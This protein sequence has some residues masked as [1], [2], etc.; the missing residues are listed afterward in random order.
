MS[1]AVR[2]VW[3]AGRVVLG[4][5]GL[6][7]ARRR[8]REDQAG[9]G[10]RGR[11]FRKY[12]LLIVGL[13][14]LVLLLNSALDFW[15]AYDEN[16]AALYR[17]QQEKAASAARRIEEF[18]DEIERQ[19]GWT[20]A[21][22]WAA[23]PLEQRRF[24]Y[25][26]LL[27]QVPPITELIQLDDNG[28]EQL[29]VSRL[30]MDVVGSEKDYSEAPSFI[31]AR[32]HRVWF[33]PVYFRKESEPYMTLA[34]ARTG[35]NA[36]V[37][38][39]EVNLKLIWDV[40]TGLKIGRGGYAYVV[41]R[42]GRLIAH[43]DISLVLRNTDLAALPQVAAARAEAAGD[44][45]ESAGAMVAKG[46]NGDRVLTAHAAIA[47]LG[48]TVFVELPLS[49]AL[50]PLY[51]SALRTAALLA[52]ALVLATLAALFLARRMT[53]PIRELQAG[54]ARIGAGEL[55]RHIDIHTG[56]ELE[57][58][59][60]DFN[61]MATDLQKSYANLEKKV[62]DRT[63]ELKEALDQQTATAEVLGVINSSPGDLA[64]VFDAVLDKATRFCDA[65]FGTL[66]TYDGERFKAVALQQVPEAYAEFLSQAPIRPVPF[67]GLGRVAAGES[68][69][70]FL[71][72]A[73]NEA[74][75][76]GDAGL[77]A[78]LELGKARSTVAVPLRKDNAVLGA[79]TAY[80]QEVRPFSDKQIA[81]LQNFAAQ[82][83]I[84]MENARLIN[85]TRE[86][87]EQQTATAEV[88][89]VINSSPSDLTPVFSAILEKAHS[90]CGV[91]F[92]SLQLYD[93]QKLRAVAMRGFPEPLEKVIRE[94]YAP[95]LNSP[96][97]GLIGGGRFVQ[98]PD[99]AERDTQAPNPRSWV[100]VDLGIRTLLFLPLRKD[101]LLLGLIS[102]ARKE[103][104]LFSEREIALLENFAAQAVIAMENAR[105][106]TETHEAL[107]QQTATAEVLQVINSS[108]GDLAPVFDAML[109]KATRLCEAPFG[110][111]R[112]W[113]GERFHLG[114][115]QG[116]PLF[117][118]WAQQRGPV[119][120]DR[121]ASPLGRILAGERVV[122][123]ADAPG[124]EGYRT[125]S[126]FRDMVEASG[127]RSAIWVALR[128]DDALLGVI[129][130]YRQEV[131]P[132]SDKQV[133]LLQNFAAQA[134]IATENA[135]LIT[136]T[137]E[138][139]E[140]QTAT[141][142]VL[143]VINSSPGD[144]A[145]V[146]DAMLEKAHSL[147]GVA[148]GALEI[149]DGE[150]VRALATRG[151]PREFE[152]LIRQGYKP[153]P[154]D[155]HWALV[156]GDRF[157]HVPN[158]GAIDDATSRT[159]AAL[160][161]TGTFLAVA[162]RKDH[163][164][165]GRIVAARQEVRPFADKEIALLENFAAQ[166]VIAMENARLITETREALE[167]QTA[168]A[169]VLQVINSSPGDLAPVFDAILEKAHTLCEAAFGSLF[170]YDGVRFCATATQ[171]LPEALRE[172]SRTPFRPFPNSP[173][174]RLTLRRAAD[175]GPRSGDRPQCGARESSIACCDRGGSYPHD[176]SRAVTQ[177]RNPARRYYRLPAGSAAV[178]RQ[179][180]DAVA[181]FRRAGRDRDRE[182]ASDHRDARG[183][184]A[185]DRDRRGL[186]GHQLL[187]RRTRAGVR[188]DARQSDTPLRSGVRNAVHL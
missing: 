42:E 155:P 181:K 157:V 105:L 59:A 107:E 36:G 144:L 45:A 23:A 108:P 109:E 88:L 113:D 18:V 170:T 8:D 119:R 187:A 1:D 26:R 28:K 149:W 47:P 51:G 35:R 72:V 115:V 62:E 183:L 68:V 138:A 22:Q 163:T 145:P 3:P 41:D 75:R 172:R 176:S 69:A 66:W 63:A 90:L 98:I 143:G 34:M 14:S 168:T 55:D 162:L 67:S 77:E 114:A 146:F 96:L 174:S 94:P 83:V 44:K 58:L 154:N 184:G 101:N 171:G 142:E 182:C 15:F 126:G 12:V 46:I 124:G 106:I 129:I 9:A 95:D 73:A 70:H 20:T 132:F 5:F 121:D 79:I 38:V 43:P 185:A 97:L 188:R 102:A 53:V 60:G 24:D 150:C 54:A 93:G 21:P 103:A 56:D 133:A 33:S 167:Q 139:L 118:D 76:G 50:A 169:E 39:A 186:A 179:A 159:A 120:P 82:A 175:S 16:K 141:A 25:V 80:R 84:A 17:I 89:Q 52:L 165:L 11:L 164:L 30:A 85:E 6:F 173:L 134:V 13:V 137:R 27:R 116:D 78:L 125:S 135:R 61:R 74:Y 166:A 122:H 7:R 91:T 140:Q 64:P 112:T 151:L 131:R 147:C 92:G 130:V 117:R 152:D 32:K 65:A 87:L 57:D 160:V 19:L 86:A 40:I 161:G 178:L 104:K 31:E 180:D 48:W 29:K 177:R 148:I 123:F 128:K 158:L 100:A 81:L 153:E 110:I 111:L 156:D 37:T 4:R 136:E 2:R 49:E 99:L 71:D 10:P 127:V